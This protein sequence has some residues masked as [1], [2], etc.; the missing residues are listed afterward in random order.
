ML[1][2]AVTNLI[3]VLKGEQPLSCVNPQVLAKA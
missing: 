2:M 1:E 3:A